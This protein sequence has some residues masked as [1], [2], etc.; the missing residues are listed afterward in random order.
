MKSYLQVSGFLLLGILLFGCYRDTDKYIQSH[1]NDI[2][3][4]YLSTDTIPADG[5]SMIMITAK[6]NAN[7]D[8]KTVQFLTTNGI[9]LNGSNTYT[10]NATQ[11]N[12]SLLASTYLKSPLDTTSF[13]TVEV[14]ASGVDTVVKIVFSNAYPDSIQLVSSLASIQSGFNNELPVQAYLIR[15]IGTP[16]LHQSARFSAYR[17]DNS[18]I[19]AFQYLNLSGSDSTGLINANFQL[20]DTLYTGRIRIVG[21]CN[22]VNRLLQDTLS[23]FITK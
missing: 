10:V 22:G 15:H 8:F 9:F 19:G 7:A 23:I 14:S 21:T 6:I 5:V 12:D 16:S 18:S 2:L 4:V 3:S 20:R 11:Q 13:E 1:K 17:D